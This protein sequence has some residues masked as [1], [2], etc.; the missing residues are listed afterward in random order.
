MPDL[1][2]FAHPA[3]LALL[4][5]LGGWTA[6]DGTSVGQFMVSRPFVAATLAGWVVGE[7][8]AGAGV[9]VLLEAFHLFVLPVG[10]ARYP[11][12]GPPS[13]VAG[14]AFALSDHR[15]GAL[16]T[17]IVF[18]L[19]W[20]WAGGASIRYLRQL[21]VYARLQG[22]ELDPDRL[23]VG[24]LAAIAADFARGLVM[25]LGGIVLFS[26]ALW[27]AA[28]RWRLGAELPRLALSVA[29]VAL[30]AGTLRLFGG[31]VRLFIAGAAAGLVA[32][33]LLP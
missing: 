31:R 7:P 32:L 13:V 3:T 29:A 27:L 2:L 30:F 25:T 21:N 1:L 8:L 5:L 10:A 24:H 11:E 33:Y 28:T 4:L 15:P 18:G 23:V 22:P 14:A 20:E 6:V 12:G 26:F 19:L 16:L 17:V 9:G